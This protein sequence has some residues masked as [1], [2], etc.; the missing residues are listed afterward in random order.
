MW[1]VGSAF[2]LLAVVLALLSGTAVPAAAQEGRFGPLQPGTAVAFNQTIPVNLV[3]VGYQ[4][5]VIDQAALL[6]SLPQHSTPAVRFPRITYGLSGRDIGLEFT[7]RYR[8]VEAGKRFEDDF[9]AY[10]AATGR[11]GELTTFQRLYNEQERNLLDVTGPVLHLEGP[12]VERWLMEQGRS[13]LQINPDRSY[14]IYLI[15]WYGRPDFRFHVYQNTG[16]TD[17]DTGVNFGQRDVTKSLA[18]GGS[19]GRTWFYDLS[20]G[21]EFATENYIVDTKDV[22]GDGIEDYRMPPIWEYAPGGYREQAALSTDLGKVVRFVAI[23]LL[24]AASP[25]YDP[26]ATAPAP[27]GAKYPFVVTFR[28]NPGGPKPEVKNTFVVEAL[29][30]FQ[31]YYDWKIGGKEV[32]PIDPGAERAFRISVDLLEEDGCW[33]DFGDPFAQLFC[34]FSANRETYLPPGGPDYVVGNFV[35][36][37]KVENMGFLAGAAGTADDNWQNGVQSFT[38]TW[39]YEQLR[40]RGRGPSWTVLHETGHHIGLSHPFDGYD[41]ELDI[42]YEPLDEFHFVAIGLQVDS[43]MSVQRTSN[44]FGQFDR[45]NMYRY[46]FAGYMN[47]SNALLGAILASPRAN[48]ARN[49][50]AQARRSAGQALRGFQN[51]DYLRAVSAARATYVTLQRAA[52]QLGVKAELPA[53]APLNPA[54]PT[55]PPARVPRFI[56]WEQ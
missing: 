12:A 24:F 18:W 11:P 13:R 46:E 52:D 51:W 48:E 23:N 31:P 7:F 14:T 38:Y 17:P 50:L 21:P 19:Y 2:I 15:N 55:A 6:G 56:D 16:S 35:F 29:R 37:T 27:G 44:S 33:N 22:D 42:D 43:V 28:D 9:F 10:L 47:W 39:T 26:L 41:P 25:L 32:D 20:A 54:Q 45:D 8:L 1:R 4:P 36:D 49:E 53:G 34:Y 5:G 40:S 30:A 3:L